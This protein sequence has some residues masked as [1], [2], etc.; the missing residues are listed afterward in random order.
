MAIERQPFGRLDD[1]RVVTRFRLSNE[2][3][4]EVAILDWGGII[5]SLW[6]P[7][8]QGRRADV[9]LGFDTLEPYVRPHPYFGALVGRCANRIAGGHLP[10]AGRVWQLDRNEGSNHLHGGSQG[11]DRVLWQATVG[12]DASGA[13][14]ELQHVSPAGDQGYPGQLHATARYTLTSGH[15]LH[16]D[17]QARCDA[18]TVVNLTQHSYFNLAGSGDILQHRLHLNAAYYLPTGPGL[19][20]T[21]EMR[22]VDGSPMDFRLPHSIGRDLSLQ[23]DA[24]SG[25]GGYDHCWVLLGA[26]SGAVV[27]EAN[28]LPLAAELLEP[29]SGRRLRL[30]VSHPGLQF[31]SGNF[32]DGTLAG[33]GGVRYGRHAGLCLEPQFFPDTP[34]H[35]R[36]PSIALQPGEVWTQ[37]SIY[38]FSA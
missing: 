28:H 24:L 18:P 38:C 13:W 2:G 5:Q 32:L 20:P 9:V 7:D 35:P 19:I 27:P 3:G 22:L 15:A 17:Y 10:L 25:A 34:H 26:E 30:H 4:L 12:E 14:V 1:G 36:F 21:G 16:I 23:H 8:R 29:V 31:Y 33:K 37:R 11:F 6:Q